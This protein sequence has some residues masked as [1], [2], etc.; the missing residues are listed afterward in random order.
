MEIAKEEVL[1]EIIEEKVIE[2]RKKK[3]IK[4]VIL[5][6][7]LPIT[8]GLSALAFHYSIESFISGSLAVLGGILVLPFGLILLS[9]SIFIVFFIIKI[10]KDKL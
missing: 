8:L 3:G 9:A 2:K 10:A 1:E 7:F 6:I 4:I 5:S